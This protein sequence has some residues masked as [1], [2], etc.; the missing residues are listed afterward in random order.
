[1]NSETVYIAMMCSCVFI[2]GFVISYLLV[3]TNW[4][5]KPRLTGY[6][7]KKGFRKF[8]VRYEDNELELVTATFSEWEKMMIQLGYK[9]GLLIR[10]C[11]VAPEDL[12]F[13]HIGII[14]NYIVSA[15]IYHF[16]THVNQKDKMLNE[17]ISR[18][19]E[20]RDERNKEREKNEDAEQLN[21]FVNITPQNRVRRRLHSN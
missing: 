19:E 21:S 8:K 15:D 4:D 16:I 3:I 20:K 2:S 10:T 5:N 1:M 17:M 11:C 13:K 14:E 7:P 12:G 18:L 9:D 6:Y